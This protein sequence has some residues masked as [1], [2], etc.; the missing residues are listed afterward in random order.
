MLHARMVVHE[1][2]NALVP[3]QMALSSLTR[4]LGDAASVE[5]VSKHARRIE[6]GL[7]RALDFAGQMLRA[8]D[9]GDEPR[10]PFDAVAAVRE[11]VA[12]VATLLNGHL[13]FAPPEGTR[14]VFGP[15]ARFVLAV[16][17]LLRN[18]AQA[19][20]AKATAGGGRVEVSFGPEGARVLIHVD[21]DGP[22][23]PPEER[24]VIFE[25][26]VAMRSG[27]SGQGL[28]LVRRA[29][30]V[31]MGGAVTCESGPLGGARF[32]IDLPTR[33]FEPP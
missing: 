4:S 30:E 18:A 9:L 33:E 23:V 20:A 7:T 27:G 11:A 31:E 10:S 29:V 28:A 12:S 32:T 13:R 21:D 25:P 1:L 5:P 15:R 16:I 6:G 17:N 22:G 3:A 24:H 14:A 26:G 19:S 2:R 8:A